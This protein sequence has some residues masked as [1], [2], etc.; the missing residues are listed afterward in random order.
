M[1]L[2]EKAGQLEALADGAATQE[3]LAM[4]TQASQK[5]EEVGQQAHAI[6][7]DLPAG[8]EA[9]GVWQQVKQQVDEAQQIAQAAM[10]KL[11]D[12]AAAVRAAGS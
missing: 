9:N 7:G 4:L 8:N 10:M 12:I 2:S 1:S 3:V 11:K 6:I 5:A